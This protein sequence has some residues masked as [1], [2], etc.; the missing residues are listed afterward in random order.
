M[1]IVFLTPYYH[2]HIGGVETHVKEICDVL[3]QQGHQVTVIT[4]QYDSNLPL[5]EK[6]DGIEIIRIPINSNQYFTKLNHKLEIWIW[7]LRHNKLFQDS[8]VVHAHDVT[9]WLLPLS[10]LVASKLYTTF[11]GWEGDYP[12]RWQAKLQRFFYNKLSRGAIHVGNWIREF[13]WD[14]PSLVM[15]GGVSEVSKKK[16]RVKSKKVKKNLQIVFLGRLEKENEINSYLGLIQEL[17]NS[18]IKNKVTWVGDGAF[19]E[20]C[21]Q[22]GKVTGFISDK[23]LQTY[24]DQA[25]LVFASSYLS[26]LAAQAS[27]KVVCAF[28]SHHL[29]RRYLETYSGAEH[30]ITARDISQMKEQIV[31]ILSNKEKRSMLERKAR[32]FAKDKSWQKVAE[33]Y[34][35][36][37]S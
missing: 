6:I 34:Q 17:S 4:Q 16:T 37:W 35:Q 23:K 27:G 11:H 33:Q 12:V 32:S 8:D 24:L 7:M 19:R 30:M 31:E 9:W 5:E 3:L 18:K 20:K 10:P 21:Q 13:Y 2:P 26:I 25:D 22:V 14:K 29:K 36:L 28:Y 15:E 1:K